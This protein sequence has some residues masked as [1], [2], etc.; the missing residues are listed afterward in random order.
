MWVDYSIE[1]TSSS[2][3]IHAAYGFSDSKF[4]CILTGMSTLSDSNQATINIGSVTNVNYPMYY[5]TTFILAGVDGAWVTSSTGSIGPWMTQ[6]LKYIGDRNLR[7]I[8]I[9]GSHDSGMCLLTDKTVVASAATAVTQHRGI[10][11]QLRLGIRFFDIRP[12]RWNGKLQCGHV[13]YI[14]DL[15]KWQGGTGQSID[16]IV[17]QVNGFTDNNPELVILNVSHDYNADNNYN[18]FSDGDWNELFSKLDGLKHRFTADKGTDLSLKPLKDFIGNNQAAVVLRFESGGDKLGD[19][20]GKGFFRTSSMPIYDSY[21]NSD[22]PDSLM[23]DQFNKLNNERSSSDNQMFSLDWA[24]TMQGAGDAVWEN[25]LHWADAYMTPRLGSD[26]L[27]RSSKNVYPNI[28][29]VDGVQFTD[30][31]AIATA[32]N[33]RAVYG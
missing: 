31:V 8:C 14:N 15:L 1:G 13:G 29:G 33:T 7:H 12:I 20:E 5:G 32:I 10:D 3:K 17:S 9:P 23:K 2:F 26:V 18:G 24:M 22:D 21:A 11:D 25:L 6:S 28:I 16:D 27:P 30:A 4:H 19:R